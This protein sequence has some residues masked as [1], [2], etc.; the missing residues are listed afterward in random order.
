M[1]EKNEIL[2]MSIEKEQ[3]QEA[4]EMVKSAANYREAEEFVFTVIR[5]EK[6]TPELIEV[7]LEVFL[8]TRENE[9]RKHGGWVHSLSHFTNI[10]WKLQM[11]EWIQK[12]NEVAFKGAAELDDPNCSDRLV[13][14]FALNADWNDD[15]ADFHLTQQNLSWMD[16]K[17]YE[18]AKALIEAGPFETEEAY[19]RFLSW[20]G[21]AQ[22]N[23][24]DTKAI[25]SLLHRLQEIGAD[26][27]EY[28][29]MANDL[30]AKKLEE[31]KKKLEEATADWTREHLQKG[32]QKTSEALH[33]K[34][35]P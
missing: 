32:I 26:T 9:K 24:V 11:V 15:P 5:E 33:A 1:S 29:N 28:D 10:L 23:L 13:D 2:K 31:L 8:G 20:D 6:S 30:L 4:I 7:V 14:D 27:S 16:W 3:F 12:F 21:E 17:Y 18:Y 35:A 34:Q 22:N 25:Q 19:L